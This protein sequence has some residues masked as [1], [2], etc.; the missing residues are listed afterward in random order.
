MVKI[1]KGGTAV[2][3]NNDYLNLFAFWDRIQAT[4][5]QVRHILMRDDD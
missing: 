2:I 3:I 5:Q 4:L 1:H